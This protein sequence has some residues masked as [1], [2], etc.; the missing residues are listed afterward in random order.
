[1]ARGK[2]G[3]AWQTRNL[4]F[5]V[6][7]SVRGCASAMSKVSSGRWGKCGQGSAS[8]S[9]SATTP[10]LSTLGRLQRLRQRCRWQRY[11]DFVETGLAGISIRSALD[12]V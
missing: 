6:N 11:I 7:E 9:G 8:G 12:A 4:N 5:H 3:F 10:T 1:M 2:T